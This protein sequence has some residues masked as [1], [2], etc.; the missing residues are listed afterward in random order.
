MIN[1]FA[2][3]EF[4]GLPNRTRGMCRRS[5]SR[6]H[7]YVSAGSTTGAEFFSLKLLVTNIK[8]YES[9]A[10]ALLDCINAHI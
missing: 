10:L 7:A 2:Y 1:E 3:L 4:E 8:V 5:E 6:V 9:F